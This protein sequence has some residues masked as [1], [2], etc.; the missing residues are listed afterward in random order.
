MRKDEIYIRE[1]GG[2]GQIILAHR[3][4]SNTN[5]FY[6]NHWAPFQRTLVRRKN[7]KMIDVLV[8]ARKYEIDVQSTTRWPIEEIK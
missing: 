2:R 4:F 7:L 5:G 3:W 1:I 8:A 6:T